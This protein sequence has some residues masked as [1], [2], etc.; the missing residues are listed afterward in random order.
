MQQLKLISL[1]E[2]GLTVISAA[3][4]DAVL[5]I[6]DLEFDKK[7]AQFLLAA[8]RFVWENS[9]VKP[10][11]PHERRRANIS[12]KR[13]TNVKIRGVDQKNS[14][15]VLSLLAIRFHQKS[16]GPEGEIE[17]VMSAN[18]GILLDVECIEVQL[19]DTGAAW[20]AK[21]KPHHGT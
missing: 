19:T 20:E 3:M 21:H 14:D 5:K 11:I 6:E 18:A 17:L 1:D 10:R 2:E 12:F 4:Q 9:S 7:N 8:N 16:D 15:D 13:V